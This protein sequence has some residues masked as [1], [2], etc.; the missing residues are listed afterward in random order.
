[1]Y[2][3]EDYLVRRGGTFLRYG[4]YGPHGAYTLSWVHTMAEATLMNLSSAQWFASHH[5]GQV[6]PG[7][8]QVITISPTLTQEVISGDKV[9]TIRRGRR[10][11]PLGPAI[12]FDRENDVAIAVEIMRTSFCLLRNIPRADRVLAGHSSH[13][14]LLDDL[15]NYYPDLTED[16]EVTVVRFN[17]TD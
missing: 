4:P 9:L 16:D 1:M 7:E 6:Y 13:Q 2:G 17:R 11:Y 15:L 5:E 10:D 3:G 8:Q 14:E 12:L